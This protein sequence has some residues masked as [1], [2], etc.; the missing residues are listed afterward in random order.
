[1]YIVQPIQTTHSID[2]LAHALNGPLVL[3]GEMHSHASYWIPDWNSPS[4]NVIPD[5]M[6][7]LQKADNQLWI[8]KYFLNKSAI[9]MFLSSQQIHNKYIACKPILKVNIWLYYVTKLVIFRSKCALSVLTTLLSK[10]NS[11]SSIR[12]GISLPHR[13]AEWGIRKILGL[14]VELYPVGCS[15]QLTCNLQPVAVACLIIEFINYGQY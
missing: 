3:I 10:I 15:L 2:H 14:A 8:S 9:N 12:N 5:L 13:Q 11:F 6:D 1:M 4:K 7:P